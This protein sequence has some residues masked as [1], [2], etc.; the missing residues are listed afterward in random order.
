MTLIDLDLELHRGLTFPGI[1][2]NLVPVVLQEI[3]NDDLQRY[4][5][6][7]QCDQEL[8][9]K[10]AYK[11][12]DQTVLDPDGE[13]VRD[14]AVEIKTC[15]VDGIM[16]RTDVLSQLG[17]YQPN[18]RPDFITYCQ[19]K[20]IPLPD[21]KKTSALKFYHSGEWVLHCGNDF[22]ARYDRARHSKEIEIRHQDHQGYQKK[23]ILASL[24][25]I[26]DQL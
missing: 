3:E 5:Y 25:K 15:W 20:N 11:A 7:F 6:R 10:I 18:Y 26:K 17:E 22:W 2:F 4:L 13:I 1:D 24:R 9:I 12:A 21:T 8:M 16:L 23:S 19:N 14:Q